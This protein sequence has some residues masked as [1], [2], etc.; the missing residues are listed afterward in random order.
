VALLVRLLGN[1]RIEALDV[2]LERKL[3]VCESTAPPAGD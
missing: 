2:E 1:Q 3:V